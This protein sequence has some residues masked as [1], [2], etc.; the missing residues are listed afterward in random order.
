MAENENA[1]S[2]GGIQVIERAARILKAL[3][4]EP[5]GMS[6]SRIAEAVSLPRS[7]VQRIVGALVAENLVMAGARGG[8]IRLGPEIAALAEYTR[9]NV[10]ETCRLILTELSQTTGETADLS[11]L[12][13]DAMIFLDQIP[14]VHRL[15]AV[16]SVG[17]AF[18]LTTTA[19][20]LACLAEL[21]VDEARARA[22]DEWRRGQVE[23]SME[24]FET[25]LA[26]IRTSG[27]AYD[28][29]EHTDGISAIGIA[30]RD[31]MG[32]LYSIS[33]PMPSSRF[34]SVKGVVEGA[35]IHT[36]RHAQRLITWPAPAGRS[37]QRPGA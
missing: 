35:I 25:R 17:D 34:P 9:L 3:K 31:W 21:P 19:N 13:G 22:R 36:K 18:P 16:S 33:V 7:T 32:N 30:F 11:V 1:G 37:G 5:S 4:H 23:R 26:E 29:D 20:G 8:G 28:L 24:D 10:V 6:L 15:R 27:L 14:G 2:R 12:R